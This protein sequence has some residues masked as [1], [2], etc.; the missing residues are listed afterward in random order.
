MTPAE[1]KNDAPFWSWFDIALFLGPVL[2][3]FA[4]PYLTPRTNAPLPKPTLAALILE[5]L[6]FGLWFVVLGIYFRVRYDEPLFRSLGWRLDW[7]KPA[8]LLWVGPAMAVALGVLGKLLGAPEL[9]PLGDVITG[10]RSAAI[11]GVFA[12]LIGPAVEELIFRGF[13][14]P[15]FVRSFGIVTGILLAAAPFV[16]M[17][18]PQYHWAWQYLALLLAAS[19][20]FGWVRVKTGSTA[21]SALVHAGYNLVYFVLYLIQR[22]D[23][24]A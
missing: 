1:V 17:H 10:V 21:A 4:L 9:D 5:F 23:L 14:L 19:A 18:G 8:N 12:V 22:K 20:V 11:T 7:H 24:F 13:L 2:A 16:L 3:L 15:L 6:I